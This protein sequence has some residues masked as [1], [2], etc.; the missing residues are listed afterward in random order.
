MQFLWN[1]I[2]WN[3]VGISTSGNLKTPMEFPKNQR[4]FEKSIGISKTPV[5]F[6]NFRPKLAGVS[7][8]S[9]FPFV[10]NSL[11][12]WVFKFPLEF[13]ISSGFYETLL[14]FLNLQRIFWNSI[15][16]FEIPLDFS[17]EIRWN[18]KLQWSFISLVNRWKFEIPKKLQPGLNVTFMHWNAFK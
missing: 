14:E 15:G 10:G 17:M 4:N 5:E 8:L 6:L 16:F 18:L 9:K 1:F 11:A 13:W 12:F 2:W 3:F 7:F